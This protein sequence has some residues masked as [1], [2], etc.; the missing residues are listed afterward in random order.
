[1]CAAWIAGWCAGSILIPL[2]VWKVARYLEDAHTQKELLDE[3]ACIADW[4]RRY[5]A[6][7]DP[8]I[9]ARMWGLLSANASFGRTHIGT[10]A[11]G[12]TCTPAQQR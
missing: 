9:Q 1:M 6:T 5:H 8:C 3:H 12:C 10:E 4:V 7:D 2:A 11:L